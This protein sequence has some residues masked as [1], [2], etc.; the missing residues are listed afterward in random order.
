MVPDSG[1]RQNPALIGQ[2]SKVNLSPIK[3]T[4]LRSGCDNE[5]ILKE[6]LYGQV[7]GYGLL[8]EPVPA[9]CDDKIDVTF[10]QR[11]QRCEVHV[12]NIEACPWES[13]HE[14]LCDRRQDG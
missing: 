14:Q 3:P 11:R 7:V 2:V 13:L 6:G 1:R 9:A 10:Q 5:F 8:R 4:A 12:I